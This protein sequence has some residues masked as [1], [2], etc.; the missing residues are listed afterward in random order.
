[1]MNHRVVQ[2]SVPMDA[3]HTNLALEMRKGGYE[4]RSSGITT[5][6]PD[7]RMTPPRDPRFR[8][9]GSL[10]RGWHSVGS[11]EPEKVQYVNWL[12]TKGLHVPERPE[13]IWLPLESRG[14]GATTSASRIPREF[15]DTAWATECAL[16]Y[17]EGM[18][19]GRGFCISATIARTQPFIARRRTTRSTIRL[20]SGPVRAASPDVEAQQH[21]LLAHYIQS[22]KQ[23]Q[24]FRDGQGLGSAIVRGG[25]APHAHGLLWHDQ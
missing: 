24:F 6:T 18:P 23:S 14:P 11:W 4:Q 12:R 3:R 10:M 9:L 15:S 1:M 21:P 7:P 16:S 25:G 19:H 22:G 8:I 13:D 2:N 5:T 17:L 20:R